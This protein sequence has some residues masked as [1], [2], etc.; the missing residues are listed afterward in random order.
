MNYDYG[1]SSSNPKDLNNCTKIGARYI[2]N[3]GSSNS[4]INFPYSS[5]TGLWGSLYV[6]GI[7]GGT[8]NVC[9][10]LIATT[11]T[12]KTEV[13]MRSSYSSGTSWLEWAQIS[14]DIPSFYKDYNDINSLAS[15]LTGAKIVSYVTGNTESHRKLVITNA[16][17]NNKS[18]LKIFYN[19]YNGATLEEYTVYLTNNSNWIL[20]PTNAS[21]ASFTSIDDMTIS[22]YSGLT[23]V[24]FN[25]DAQLQSA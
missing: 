3:P 21:A 8:V 18:F 24:A 13:W 16:T 2:I 7:D 19:Q 5:G 9:Q 1:A 10:T 17:N 23:V 25:C 6:T 15:A 14:I 20:S 22:A 11:N 4:Y 12:N